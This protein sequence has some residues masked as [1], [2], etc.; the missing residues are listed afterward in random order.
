LFDWA[1]TLVDFVREDDRVAFLELMNFLKKKDVKLPE[2]ELIFSEYQDLFYGLIKESRQTHREANFETVLRYLFFKYGIEVENRTSWKDI[3]TV[4]Y[5][6]IHGVRRVYPDVVSTL[7]SFRE[8]GI[9]MG[10]ISNTTNPEFIKEEELCRTGLSTYFEFAIFSSS[11]PYRKPHP[12]IFNA[13][14]SR[15]NVE[16]ENILFVGDDLKIDVMGAQSVG[17]PT[18]WLN[19]EGSSLVENISPHYQITSLSELLV[20]E[21]LKVEN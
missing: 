6:V 13:A 1:Y 7:K 4:Y 2:F 14:I 12:S 18:A 20:M 5:K 3:L 8:S 16:A 10:I 19:R 9:R 15:L 17:M 21:S 11:T